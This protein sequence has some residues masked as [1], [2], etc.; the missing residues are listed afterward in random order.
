VKIQFCVQNK[1]VSG[2]LH[3]GLMRLPD[4][5]ADVAIKVKVNLEYSTEAHRWWTGV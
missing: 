1:Q 5:A 3:V 4:T 2:Q